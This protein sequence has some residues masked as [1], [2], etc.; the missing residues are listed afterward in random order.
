V[1]TTFH[2]SRSPLRWL[3]PVTVAALA[4]YAWWATGVT[5]FTGGAYV[6][7]GV[8]VVTVA[9]AAA[10]D[11]RPVGTDPVPTR[12]RHA[13][14]FRAALPWVLLGAVALVLELVAL[15]LGGRSHD[16][17]TLST[18]VDHALGR[19]PQRFVLFCVWLA[20]AA[21]PLLRRRQRRGRGGGRGTESASG[22]GSVA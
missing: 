6:A 3:G 5:P 13:G 17:P 19:H 2:P 7:V 21:V 14:G 20:V 10:L 15:S 22:T 1:R 16:V 9:V 4:A 11:R 18:V 12:S 8:P